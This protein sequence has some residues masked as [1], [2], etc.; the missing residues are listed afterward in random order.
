MKKMR[1]LGRAVAPLSPQEL[2]AMPT[3]ALLA[4]LKRLQWCEEAKEKSDL[5]DEELASA[6]HLVVFKSD[7]RWRSA[8]AD[9]KSVLAQREQVTNKP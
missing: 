8:Y 9:L 3:G 1:G 4:R 7:P 2:D 6:S 5:S